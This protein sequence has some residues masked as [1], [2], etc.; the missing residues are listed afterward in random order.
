MKNEKKKKKTK[1]FFFFFKVTL[2]I[3][4]G[5]WGSDGLNRRV[6]IQKDLDQNNKGS[7]IEMTL[8]YYLSML[9]V[10]M[11]RWKQTWRNRNS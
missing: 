2:Q 9:Y 3:T 10:C 1:A 7:L 8:M 11:L 6:R 5:G 4:T